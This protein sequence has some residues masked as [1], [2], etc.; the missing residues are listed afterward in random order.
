MKEKLSVEKARKRVKIFDDDM[1]NL[2]TTEVED[3]YVK[4]AMDEFWEVHDSVASMAQNLSR[5][6]STLQKISREREGMKGTLRLANKIGRPLRSIW[7]SWEKA[8]EEF[9]FVYDGQV[10]R[11]LEDEKIRLQ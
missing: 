11:E 3:V 6:E 7:K 4:K 5:L 1:A 10:L 2:R 8:Y 9:T